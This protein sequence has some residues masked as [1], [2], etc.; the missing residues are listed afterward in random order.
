MP[1]G[2]SKYSN[3]EDWRCLPF[4]GIYFPCLVDLEYV[5]VFF[6]PDLLLDKRLVV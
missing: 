3:I 4:F 1:L 5:D 6:Q 2:L